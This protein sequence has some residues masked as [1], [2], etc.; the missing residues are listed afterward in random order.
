MFQFLDS[1]FA[2]LF[3]LF[4]VA[5]SLSRSSLLSL[6]TLSPRTWIIIISSSWQSFSSAGI[7]CFS[8]WLEIAKYLL[9]SLFNYDLTSLI[10]RS[11]RGLQ[12]ICLRA[13]T[14]SS[15]REALV[16]CQTVC[17]R[18]AALEFGTRV[19]ELQLLFLIS[20]LLRSH[21]ELRLW[22]RCNSKA[23]KPNKKPFEWPL[24]L[25]PL[26]AK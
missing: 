4:L 15:P 23:K 19:C 5:L 13:F 21:C 12:I 8:S 14:S 26:W 10:S 22:W 2:F 17:P 3:L 18:Y 24:K 16:K 1:L 7:V 25:G 20:M 6:K 9:N 11:K